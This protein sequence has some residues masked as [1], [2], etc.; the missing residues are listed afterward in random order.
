MPK[1]SSREPSKLARKPLNAEK[2]FAKCA[3]SVI[4]LTYRGS[5]APLHSSKMSQSSHGTRKVVAPIMME[6]VSPAAQS[7]II[8]RTRAPEIWLWTSHLSNR[9][10]WLNSCVQSTSRLSH[11]VDS[12]W[13]ATWWSIVFLGRS[14]SNNLYPLPMASSHLS[15][16]SSLCARSKRFRSHLS[17][18]MKR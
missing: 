15:P 13:L 11:R 12:V 17:S 6:V 8:K 4:R 1:S 7:E 10:S 9:T 16:R 5:S 3:S 14:K 2:S 18:M